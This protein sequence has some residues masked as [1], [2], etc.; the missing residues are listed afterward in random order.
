[1]CRREIFAVLQCF[2]PTQARHAWAA[3]KVGTPVGDVRHIYLVLP[4]GGEVE[5]EVV[6]VC[7]FV[8]EGMSD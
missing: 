4:R 6:R 1:M 8:S 3:I 5:E 2:P 7:V